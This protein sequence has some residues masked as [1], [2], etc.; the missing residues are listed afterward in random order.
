MRAAMLSAVFAA[1]LAMTVGAP[2]RADAQIVITPTVSG[3]PYVQTSYWSPAYNYSYA[4][5]TPYYNT[6][7]SYWGSPYGNYN[8]TWVAPRYN[9]GYRYGA[10]PSRFGWA[11][12]SWR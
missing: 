1:A 12:R 9:T 7:T 10:W 3:S 6:Y 4:A 11:T 2:G 8:G 5:T